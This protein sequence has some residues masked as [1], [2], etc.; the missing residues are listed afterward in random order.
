MPQLLTMKNVLVL[1][2]SNASLIGY[3]IEQYF[4]TIRSPKNDFNEKKSSLL[5]DF[6]NEQHL[7]VPLNIDMIRK[8]NYLLDLS[9][10]M[11]LFYSQLRIINN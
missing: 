2:L 4:Y 8:D 5:C 9:K 11:M 3:D 7:E 1:Y 6:V 10:K